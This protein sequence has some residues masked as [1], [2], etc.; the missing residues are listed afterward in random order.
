MDGDNDGSVAAAPAVSTTPAGSAPAAAAPA[1]A[2]AS[3]AT[4]AAQYGQQGIIGALQALIT[5]LSNS[6]LLSGST[7]SGLSSDTLSQLNTAFTKLISDLKGGTA[8]AAGS[9]SG[10]GTTG[11]TGTTGDA[12]S[13]S[14]LQSFLS[15]FLQDLQ[16]QGSSTPTL[17]GT[18]NT[19]A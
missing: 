9:G 10:T 7:S 1:A 13:T 8:A 18:V 2:T 11:T 16:N 12:S 6:Q 17:G 5:D 4:G 19:T 14:A 3:G 15:S